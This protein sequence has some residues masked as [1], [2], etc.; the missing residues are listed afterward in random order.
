MA[1]ETRQSLSRLFK[2][3]LHLGRDP[4][5]IRRSVAE[6]Q[7]RELGELTRYF[8]DGEQ[9]LA[10]LLF[11]HLKRKGLTRLLRAPLERE[12]A[13][14]YD[15]NLA[16]NT[17]LEHRLE[18]ALARFARNGVRALVL[19][20]ASALTTD[21]AAFSDAFVLSDIDLL[22]KPSDMRRAIDILVADG[23]RLTH[24]QARNGRIKQGLI[25]ADGVTRLDLHSGLFWTTGGDYVDYVA[26][27][28]WDGSRTGSVREHPV[29][30]LSAEHQIC[31][32]LVHDSIAHND[33]ALPTS[34]CR[35]YYLCALVD[36]YRD[37]IDWLS[38]RRRLEKQDT[39]RLL[40]AYLHYGRRE[41]GLRLPAAL[42]ADRRDV[43]VSLAVIDAA[44]GCGRRLSAY[45]HRTSIAA[46]TA[47]TARARVNRIWVLLRET[48]R[49]SASLDE[50][51]RA[52]IDLPRLTLVFKML[53][54][55]LAA[56]LY[57][58][59][60]CVR[61]SMRGENAHVG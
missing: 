17:L 44:A 14:R 41:L 5:I 60:Y 24:A 6:L 11:W 43:L 38:L 12:V 32:R 28:L 15:R 54:L 18:K 9:Q 13:H 4:S 46:L 56:L 25:G 20:G 45:T 33:V 58:G 30:V 37:R 3:C 34:I 22:V 51:S 59:G 19:K 57:V 29:H 50:R 47:R 53:C 8:D 49:G 61:Q 27:D 36:F 16:R 39:D 55:Q 26:C 10:P 42:E 40:V 1:T 31:H 23:Y 35:L 48:L 7:R 52:G 2:G 21:L